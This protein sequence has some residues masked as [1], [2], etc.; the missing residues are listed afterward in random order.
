MEDDTSAYVKSMVLIPTPE[1]NVL[2]FVTFLDLMVL[3]T[4]L[5]AEET[6]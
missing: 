6:D 1:L 3:G 5:L 2:S 4:I